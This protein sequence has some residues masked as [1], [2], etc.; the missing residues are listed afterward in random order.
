MTWYI[1]WRRADQSVAETLIDEPEKVK[2]IYDDWFEAGRVIWIE[3]H[4]GRTIDRDDFDLL[5]K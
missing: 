3:D 4:E 1:K 2:A 5:R